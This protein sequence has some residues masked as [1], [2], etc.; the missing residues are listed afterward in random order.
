MVRILS[1]KILTPII[2][3]IILQ[4]N[5]Y[6]HG[7]G[8]RGS[9]ILNWHSEEISRVV[10]F[11]PYDA[12]GKVTVIEGKQC[13]QGNQFYFDVLNNFAFDLDESIEL[14]IEFDLATSTK[15]I[16]VDYD[17]NGGIS[18]P[19]FIDL[20]IQ[21]DERF[22][23]E[24][25]LLERA[26]FA[27]RI[28]F[29]TDFRLSGYDGGDQP[30][31][32]RAKTT[33][34]NINIVRSF[35]TRRPDNFGWINL[36]IQN[37]HG[38]KTPARIALYDDS[39]R[40][41]L[42]AMSALEIKDFSDRTRT[43][44]LPVGTVNWPAENRYAFY[45]DGQYRMRLPTGNYR[46]TVTKGIE[47]R[48]T[49][50]D[51]YVGNDTT[52]DLI[53]DLERWINMPSQ[54]WISGDIHVHI[55]RN[56]GMD[57]HSLWLQAQAE[58]LHVASTLKMGNIAATHF[59]QSYWGI[60]GQYGENIRVIVAGQED[61]RTA[62]RGHTIHL[63]LREPVRNPDR[64]L[65]YHEVFE[66]VAEQHGISGYGHLNR[67]GA[68]VGMALDVPYGLV[69][70]IEVLQRGRLGTDVWFEFLNLGYKIAPAAGSDV[71]YGARIGDVRSYVKSGNT[72]FPDTWF[73]GL[74]NAHTFVTNGPILSF[75]LNGF[76]MGNEVSLDSGEQIII[77]VRASINPDIDLLDRIELIEQ[78][79]VINET[80]SDNGSDVL[81]LSHVLTAEHGT[82]FVVRAYG[83]NQQSG[84]GS[85][86]AISA[87]IYVSVDGQKSWRQDQVVTLANKMKFE[88]DQLSNLT[89]E[90]AGHLDEWFETSAAWTSK[91]PSQHKNLQ[92]RIKQAKAKYD[93]LIKLSTRQ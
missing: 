34:C 44:L 10:S 82:W 50:R 13:L 65:L 4:P 23:T 61:P 1:H 25:V 86:A 60:D 49:E 40:M 51:F 53:V 66:K 30:R 73:T 72:K 15:K 87:P 63:N 18:I 54:G 76:E 17:K 75:E 24:R 12:A 71:P 21:N 26:R 81:E 36:T 64:Y 91:W 92:K 68:R 89:L 52:L 90:S 39:N 48:F 74:S 70:F 85:V 9:Q 77:T 88:L 22:H 79:D 31:R 78:G 43:M 55:P 19:T 38:N 46:L 2:F 6:T 42:P 20:P 7:I 57:N 3:F 69:N 5:A 56:D 62:V 93:E 28:D 47:Y 32:N 11:T 84:D 67:L 45:I 8:A 14:V 33:I 80:I 41:P 35:S 29:G 58:D 16:R 37:E 59:P 27:G 83:K